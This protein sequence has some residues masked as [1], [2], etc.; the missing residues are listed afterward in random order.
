MVFRIGKVRLGDVICYEVGFDNLVASEVTAG[1]N[2]LTEQTNDADFELDGQTGRDAAAAG[3][4]P[5]PGDRVRPGHGGRGHDRGQRDHRAGRAPDR[6]QPDLAAGLLEARVPL[7]SNATLAERLGEWPEVVFSALAVAA[8]A[9][10]IGSETAAAI[11]ARTGAGPQRELFSS[12]G[13]PPTAL[14]RRLRAAEIHGRI[15]RF[16]NRGWDTGVDFWRAFSQPV[17]MAALVAGALPA[18]A[19]PAPNLEFVAWFGL[20]PG[21]LLL[22]AAPSRREAAVRGWWFGIGFLLASLYW[23]APDSGPGCC[24]SPRSSARC[25]PVSASRP[26]GC[27]ARR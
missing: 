4:G 26:G 20:I 10:A 24:W 27:C 2:L 14:A 8:L 5:D 6:Q 11:A 25:G 1:A 23:L 18:L 3:H 12:G 19:F 15:R 7:L 16:G 22:R 13:R 9:W 17:A 21:M